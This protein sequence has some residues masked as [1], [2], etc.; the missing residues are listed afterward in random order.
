MSEAFVH[1]SLLQERVGN[2]VQCNVCA[3]RCVMP[4]DGLGWC[5]TRQNRAGTLMTLTYGDVS[6]QAANPI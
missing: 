6:S 4:I 2:K 5:R 1:E 3:R